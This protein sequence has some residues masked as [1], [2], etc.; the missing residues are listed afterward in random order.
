MIALH[1]I[2]QATHFTKI[3]DLR[4]DLLEAL[5]DDAAALKEANAPPREALAGRTLACIF[6][7]PSTRTRVSLAVA[8]TRLGAASI[9]LSH[10]DLQL[11][12][13]ET[14]ADTARS[15][16]G[17][18]DAIAVRADRQAT[19]LELAHASS[20]PVLN[21]LTHEHH[22]CQALA[23]LLTIREAFGDLA[24]RH[25]AFVGDGRD[26]VAHSLLE[27]CALAGM[28]MTVA[29][30][31]ACEPDPDI[32]QGAQIVAANTGAELRIVHDP[33]AAV[34]GA[35]AVYTD[36]W[37]SMG[38]EAERDRRRRLLS[39]F[40]VTDELMAL[41]QPGALFMHCLPARRGEEVTAAVIDGAQSVV[42]Q[43]S[44]NRLPTTEAVLLWLILDPQ[45]WG[46]AN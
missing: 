33:R 7:R 11:G 31:P 45:S 36:V 46:S 30:P 38:D 34:D 43:Q 6:E 29:C 26:N 40:R 18:V 2:R 16:S 20:V 37:T 44:A 35:H 3:A 19:V 1:E 8:A 41:A 10:Q 21:A 32:F 15:L 5:L 17:Y 24:G 28:Q 4:S 23:D 13:G 12:R 39:P 14:L 9:G 22:P 25:L 27:A 42:W